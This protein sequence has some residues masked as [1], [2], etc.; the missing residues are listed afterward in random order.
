VRPELREKNSELRGR[1]C[2]ADKGKKSHRQTIRQ[3]PTASRGSGGK[4]GGGI[5][6]EETKEWAG[7]ET[8]I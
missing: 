7:L 1:T 6:I 5:G 2:K 4:R 3:Q 8:E